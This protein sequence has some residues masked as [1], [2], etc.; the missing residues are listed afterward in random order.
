VKASQSGLTHAPA[1]EKGKICVPAIL[2]PTAVGKTELA[3]RLAC[4]MDF[5][6]IS[7]DSRQIYRYMDIATAKPS[8]QQLASAR[9]WMIDIVE[10]T[11]PFSAYEYAIRAREIIRRCAEGGRKVVV[12]GGTGLYYR[13]LTQDL[14]PGVGTDFAF[15]AECERR[16]AENGAKA[17]HDDLARVDPVTARRLHPNDVHRIIRALQVFNDTGVPLSR[18]SA[19]RHAPS[20][21]VFVPVVLSR[22]RSALY[23]LIDRR[24]EQMAKEGLWDEFTA[25]RRRGY[26]RDTPGMACVGYRELFDVEEKMV[27]MQEAIGMIQRSTRRFAKR[28]MTW[29]AYQVSAPVFDVAAEGACERIGR[30]IAPC[31]GA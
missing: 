14:H 9:H 18:H 12:C 2:G 4:E 24:V 1:P 11:C 5:D 16:A 10:P 28:Q 27:T 31:L 21:M 23:G 20:D 13:S 8:P 30:Y 19:V 26:R 6:I 22:P 25:L 3:V 29:F 7:C 17:L 15:R